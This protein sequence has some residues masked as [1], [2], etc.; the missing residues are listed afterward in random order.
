MTKNYT[1]LCSVQ[2]QGFI[3]GIVITGVLFSK[4]SDVT[5]GEPWP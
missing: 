1:E 3:T 2:V 4:Y 5:K